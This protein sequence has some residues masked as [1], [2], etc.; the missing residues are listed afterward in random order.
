MRTK[1]AGRPPIT[2]G[3][4]TR[5]RTGRSAGDG[6][7]R[8]EMSC[9]R[10]LGT[11]DRC[12]HSIGDLSDGIVTGSGIGTGTGTRGSRPPGLPCS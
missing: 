3:A 10:C 5:R 1:N 7:L 4:P 12:R 9:P 11:G 2:H 6:R 8:P